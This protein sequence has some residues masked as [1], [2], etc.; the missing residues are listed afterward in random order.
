MP[1]AAWGADSLMGVTGVRTS[2]QRACRWHGANAPTE[3]AGLLSQ[4]GG[5]PGTLRGT[6]AGWTELP[7]T[8]A[9]PGAHGS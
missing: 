1:D 3:E 5:G 2:R 8:Q 9:R 4:G 7:A 6:R